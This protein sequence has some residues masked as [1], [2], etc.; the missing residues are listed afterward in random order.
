MT[1]DGDGDGD[2][3]GGHG[4]GDSGHGG[5]DGGESDGDGGESGGDGGESGGDKGH[6]GTALCASGRRSYGE[7]QV[8]SV[9]EHG[10]GGASRA[11]R[12]TRGGGDAVH[13]TVELPLP[14]PALFSRR[15]HIEFRRVAG[16]LCPG[17]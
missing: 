4:G 5:R 1:G 6:F 16:A 13:D 7:A 11:D 9:P 17:R 2:D 12:T 15:R 14:A 10:P 3:D 8:M